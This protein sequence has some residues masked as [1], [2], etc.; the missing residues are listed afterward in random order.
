MR[1][2]RRR[3]TLLATTVLAGCGEGTWLGDN[4]AAPL[5]GERKPVLLLENALAPDPRL[6][7]LT[8]EL[9]PPSRN[10]DWPMAGG[11]PQHAMGHLQAAETIKPAWRTSIGE[12]TGGGSVL[13]ASPVVADGRVA[14]VDAAGEI[15]AFDAAD[16][17]EL[18]RV[19]PE[20]IEEQD[21]LR[22]GAAAFGDDG[23]LYVALADGTVLA[24]EPAT[25]NELWR[26]S[27]R[28]PVR[29]A[30]T[31]LAGQVL[32][33]TAD[34]QLFA[35]DGA[36]GEISWRHSGV[37]EQAGIL[38]GASPAAAEGVAVVTYASGEVVALSL[39]NGQP[40]W[41]ETVLRPRRTLAIGAISDIVGDPVITGDRVV[42]A[43]ASGEMAAF[44]FASGGRVWT[45]ELTS[46]Q[47][48]WVAGEFIYLLSERNELVCLLRQGGRVRWVSP[49]GELADPEDPESVRVR[50]AGPVLVTDRLLLA[51]S[52]AEVVSVS[53]Y[54][55]EVLGREELEGPVTLPPVVA[56]GTVYFLTDR[57]DLLAYR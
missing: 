30:P 54:T 33:P 49:L 18:W 57:G 50:W 10:L 56:D 17:D 22:A 13:L 51:S 5:P 9:P 52:Q 44:D 21:R 28:A 6:G 8:V 55:G 12:G 41:S 15:S 36:T 31:A 27:L 34:S 2:A 23:R 25:G 29:A 20:G 19:E 11:N 32:V 3:F 39:A 1:L 7:A 53:P 40:L 14:A 48:P 46:T 45:A 38:G 43:G 42:V 37:F 16:G 4:E 24:L 26:R 47:T 35:L